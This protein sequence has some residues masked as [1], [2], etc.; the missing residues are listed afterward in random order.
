MNFKV[1]GYVLS[2]LILSVFSLTAMQEDR[3][4]QALQGV[5][6]TEKDSLLSGKKSRQDTAYGLIS[7]RF[8]ALRPGD[9]E[10]FIQAL[11]QQEAVKVVEPEFLHRAEE[12]RKR[13]EAAEARAVKAE[14]KIVELHKQLAQKMGEASGAIATHAQ[15][16]A[17][18]ST[19]LGT[20]VPGTTL[21]EDVSNSLELLFEKI[22]KLR[23]EIKKL[24]ETIATLKGS[25]NKVAVNEVLQV[26]KNDPELQK[27]P[28]FM[29]DVEDFFE[30][31]GISFNEYILKDFVEP[32]DYEKNLD[33][34]GKGKAKFLDKSDSLAALL[35]ASRIEIPDAIKGFFKDLPAYKRKIETE[36][37]LKEE[38]N[39]AIPDF[40]PLVLKEMLKRKD[41]LEKKLFDTFI[42]NCI[43]NQLGM[44][45]FFSDYFDSLGGVDAFID[46]LVDKNKILD[47]VG[48]KITN[49]DF[50]NKIEIIMTS[51]KSRDKFARESAREDKKNLI[52]AVESYLKFAKALEKK[53]VDL[54]GLIGKLKGC[55]VL[56]NIITKEIIE[57][58][59][60]EEKVAEAWGL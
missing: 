58:Y 35:Y 16:L 5:T 6:K 34:I 42:S 31:Q 11:R 13:A 48:N 12:D 14:Q 56:K 29:K 24:E 8:M 10:A 26:L 59:F 27:E 7:N 51:L 44:N 53:G 19:Q 36:D 55:I 50:K 20:H 43:K 60:P 2:F 25:I 41:N 46:Q 45:I 4:K 39:K 22:N 30:A 28:T 3:F 52:L 54:T 18:M 1:L 38:I 47:A 9:K 37:G 32:S 17:A 15:E 49:E 40:F 23:E 33:L 21:T 57:S